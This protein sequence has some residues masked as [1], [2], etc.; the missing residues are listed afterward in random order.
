MATWQEEYKWVVVKA[1][2]AL[3]AALVVGWVVLLPR[4]ERLA[5]LRARIHELETQVERQT[6]VL[7]EYTRMR[8][9]LEEQLGETLPVPPPEPVPAD[10]LETLPEDMIRMARQSGLEVL[11]VVVSPGS[12]HSGQGRMMMQ[13]V[14]QGDLANFKAMYRELGSRPYLDRV[15]RVEMRAAPS[16]T[17]F[18]MELWVLLSEQRRAGAGQ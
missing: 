2:V 7:P 6:L 14:V 5:G 10:A 15:D 9:Q 12:L 3:M 13:C 4:F 16:G 8:A 1:A 18:F 11:D 17:E